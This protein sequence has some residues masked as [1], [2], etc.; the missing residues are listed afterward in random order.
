MPLQVSDNFNRDDAGNLGGNWTIEASGSFD[1][2]GARALM[3]TGTN[4]LNRARYTAGAAPVDDQKIGGLLYHGAQDSGYIGIGARL[5]AAD[6]LGY[7]ARWT[8][9]S[10]GSSF[11]SLKLT[12]GAIN[13][14]ELA[15]LT[16]PG[17]VDGDRIEIE[18]IGNA[19]KVYV[20]GVEKLS[21]TDS[22]YS[23]GR[24]AISGIYQTTPK[25]YD[26]FEVYGIGTTVSPAA[27]AAAAASISPSVLIIVFFTPASASAAA[28][29]VAPTAVSSSVS[30]EPPPAAAVASRAAPTVVLG[31]LT[32]A[33]ALGSAVAGATD[34][35]VDDQTLVHTWDVQVQLSEPLLHTWDVLQ[36]LQAFEL[37]HEWDIAAAQGVEI[38]H[39]WDVIPG[40]LVTLFG[41]DIQLPTAT[42]D[43][44]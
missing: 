37:L 41:E 17:I 7:W 12:K 42:V 44:S 22:D 21:A 25:Q 26:D 13:G 34:P 3:Q 40:E 24:G 38:M 8:N 4:V 27:R 11:D 5:N 39:T 33:P 10:S 19:I 31:S 18:C 6:G 15:T 2:D 35:A 29:T 36:A 1:T 32:I 23:A 20:N 16:N 14:T 9:H 30:I 43:K 28:A